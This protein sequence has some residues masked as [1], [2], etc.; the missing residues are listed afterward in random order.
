MRE[1]PGRAI[2]EGLDEVLRRLKFTLGLVIQRI[3]TTGA[4]STSTRVGDQIELDDGRSVAI[5]VVAHI[6]EDEA[7]G[8]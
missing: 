7:E 6:I 2:Y 4:V 1:G 8:L 3:E 5:W